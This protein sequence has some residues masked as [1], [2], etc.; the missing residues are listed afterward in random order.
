MIKVKEFL[1]RVFKMQNLGISIK[2]GSTLEKS[3]L[4]LAQ[5]ELNRIQ[6]LN[7]NIFKSPLTP[8][9]NLSALNKLKTV[10]NGIKA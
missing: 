3:G 4:I 1:K 2:I 7:Q 6:S 8:K 9:A 5:K 10:L